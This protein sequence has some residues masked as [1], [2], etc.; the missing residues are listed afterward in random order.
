MSS[1][2]PP[3]RV[4]PPAFPGFSSLRSPLGSFHVEPPEPL[5]D[6]HGGM[7][8]AFSRFSRAGDCRRR[9]VDLVRDALHRP[10]IPME[11]EPLP[12]LHPCLRLLLRPAPPRVPGIRRRHRLRDP[13]PRE[14]PSARAPRSS[15]SSTA[16]EGRACGFFQRDRLLPAP[17]ASIPTHPRLSR[18][19][20]PLPQSGGHPHPVTAHHPRHRPP[21]S[22]ALGAVSVSMSLPILD[23]A[24]CQAIEPGA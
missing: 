15:V 11:R 13:H 24:L 21:S 1:V 6:H 2:A 18:S 17:R 4:S 12:G 22:P 7:G 20:C 19:V 23:R 14:A 16:L 9:P 3:G 10:A 8:G 5:P